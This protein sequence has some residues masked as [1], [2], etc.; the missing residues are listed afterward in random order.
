MNP[1]AVAAYNEARR[2]GPRQRE[3]VACGAGFMAGER[4]P[5]SERCY[6]CR[7]RRKAEQRRARAAH[8]SNHGGRGRKPPDRVIPL[9]RAVP[10]VP[11]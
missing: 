4:G 11:A 3:C 6:E 9:Y 10:M 8:R 2:V 1:E 5:T 7:A